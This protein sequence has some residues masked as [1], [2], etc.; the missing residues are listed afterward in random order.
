MPLAC[1]PCPDAAETARDFSSHATHPTK[2]D[3]RMFTRVLYF[4]TVENCMIQRLTTFPGH[5]LV[6]IS[7][8]HLCP[9]TAALR[10]DYFLYLDLET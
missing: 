8:F 4:G 6:K 5:E 1:R 2:Q 10:H 9:D 7:G 3:N